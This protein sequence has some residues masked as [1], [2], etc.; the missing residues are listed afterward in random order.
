MELL[1]IDEGGE[2]G[3]MFCELSGF[4]KVGMVMEDGDVRRGPAVARWDFF[5]PPGEAG[6]REPHLVEQMFLTAM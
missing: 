2:M 4:R 5:T 3:M 1:K 6:V